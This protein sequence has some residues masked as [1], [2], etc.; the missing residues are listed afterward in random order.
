MTALPSRA[1]PARA[2]RVALLAVVAALVFAVATPWVLRPWFLADDELPASDLTLGT[3]EDTDLLLNAWILAWIARAA[4]SSPGEIFAGNIFHPAPNAV[5]GSENM[6]AHLPVS[7]PVWMATKSALAV[8]K[9]VFFESFVLSGLAM[10]AF[11]YFHTRSFAAALVAG[12]A[13][14]L[15]PWRVQNVPHPQYL[16]IQWIPLALLGVDLW[17]ERRRLA[18]LALLAA[19]LALQ[20]LAS[21]YL[22]YFAFLLVPVYA[23]VRL[24]DVREERGRAALGLLAGG[25]AGALAAAPVA[26]PY[27]MARAQG[28]IPAYEVAAWGDWSFKPWWYVGAPFLHRAGAVVLA[29]VA[30]DLVI[31]AVRRVRGAQVLETWRCERA[32]WIVAAIAAILSAGPSLRLPG[33][34]SIPTP[35]TLLAEIV[36]GF[37]VVRGPGRFFMIVL[38]CLCAIAGLAFARWSAGWTA[39]R[40]TAAALAAVVAC[41]LVAAPRPARTMSA[42]LGTSTPDVYDWLRDHAGNDA[43]LELPAAAT[44]H[45]VVGNRRNAAYMLAST[46]HWRPILN[47]VTGHNPPIARFYNA[48]TRR[49]PDPEALG[50]LVDVVDVR[51]IVLHRDALLPHEQALWKNVDAEGLA[52]VAQIGEAEVFRVTRPPE[53][54]WRKALLAAMTGPQE[55]TFDGISTAP[56]GEACRAARI[57]SVDAPEVIAMVPVPLPVAVELENESECRWPT[58]GV[59]ARGLVGLT[60]RW[61]DPDGQ[62]FVYP[63]APFSPFVATVEPKEKVRDTLVVVPPSGRDG[64]WRLEVELVQWGEAAPLAS[65]TVSVEV[66][67]FRDEAPS[68][69]DPYPEPPAPS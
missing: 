54:D 13:F 64:L 26:I 18:A 51:W 62:P 45:D 48:I 33:G 56:L 50:L 21:L 42:Q 65:R 20:A 31:R 29:I 22:G 15:A 16:G 14:T 12:A 63:P 68:G 30:L 52:P 40:A 28:M 4:T 35:Y 69:P 17:I 43:V 47:G 1:P 34:L 9:A 58:L 39:K 55:K 37:A 11:V 7:A 8:L 46:Q 61:T 60:Y 23:L 36:P 25:A 3:M 6:L 44:D 2:S 5:A 27:W 57:L 67:S 59:H 10:W 41:A 19:S 53:R 49:L 38:V 24:A 32:L 66:R